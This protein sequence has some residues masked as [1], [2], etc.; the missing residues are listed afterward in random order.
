MVSVVAIYM[1][2]VEKRGLEWS[3]EEDW[4]GWEMA[5]TGLTNGRWR[6]SKVVF[7]IELQVLLKF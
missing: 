3:E 1:V 5:K 4:G 6:R 7:Q 2:S